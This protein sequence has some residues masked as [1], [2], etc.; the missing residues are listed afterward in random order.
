MGTGRG[1]TPEQNSS[2]LSYSIVIE[3]RSSEEYS[4][5][6]TIPE[7][8]PTVRHQE[9]VDEPASDSQSSKESSSYEPISRT[10]DKGRYRARY[11]RVEKLRFRC[12]AKF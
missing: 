4:T 7:S 11:G 12:V 5:S 10:P 6:D 9:P 2:I 3:R 1:F 8:T